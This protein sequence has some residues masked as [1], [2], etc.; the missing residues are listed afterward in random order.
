M[1]DQ[2]SAGTN[3]IKIK[4]NIYKVNDVPYS[5]ENN[6]IVSIRLGIGSMYNITSDQSKALPIY[7][8]TNFGL[9]FAITSTAVK[10]YKDAREKLTFTIK[11]NNCIIK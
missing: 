5:D 11:A 7:D 1:K 2:Y 6:E 9:I 10:I 4:D 3:A 8:G